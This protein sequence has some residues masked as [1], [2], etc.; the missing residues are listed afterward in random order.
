[1]KISINLLPPEALLEQTKKTNF[2]RI[3]VVGIATILFL[4]FLASLTLALQ[5]LQNHNI[6]NV[7]VKVASAEQRVEGLKN[8]QVELLILKDRLSV[9]GQYLG[10]SSKQSMIYKLVNKL[11]PPSAVVN[12][13]TVD[14]DGIVTLLA[15]IPD[16]ESLD[17]FISDLLDQEKNDDQIAQVSIDSLNRGLEGMYRLSLKIKPR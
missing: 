7:K 3:Q 14:K 1:M 8:T 6:S 10:I 16:R 17:L 2:Y 9:I 11:I 13:V 5:I 12:A 15:L 4:I